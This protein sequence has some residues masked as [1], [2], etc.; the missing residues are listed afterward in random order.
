VHDVFSHFD[1]VLRAFLLTLELFVVA[2]VLSL[3]FGTVL[4]ACRVGPVWV[5]S[6][7]G[8]AYVT[9]V[10]NT[11]LLVIFILVFLALPRLELNIGSFFVKGCLALTVYTSAFVCEAIRAG[12]NSVPLGQ[13]EAS[14]AI[15][16]TFSQSMTTVVLP[17]AIRAVV[18]PLASV[19][20]AL[21][22][23]TSVAAAFGLAEATARMKGFTNDNADARIQIFILFALGYIVIVEILSAGASGLESR[24]RVAR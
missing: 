16:F 13:A 8:A 3:V 5:L 12:I 4:A 19:L 9:L 24:W 7:A 21:V 23:N 20:I 6:K 22:K 2:A 1:V 10:R 14:R 17:Q 15:G 11:P 18:P